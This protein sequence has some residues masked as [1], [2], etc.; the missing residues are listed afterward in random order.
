MGPTRVSKWN[1]LAECLLVLVVALPTFGL[2]PQATTFVAGATGATWIGSAGRVLSVALLGFYMPLLYVVGRGFAP[3]SI[4][5]KKISIPD[6]TICGQKFNVIDLYTNVLITGKI[7]SGKTSVAIWHLMGE[8][9]TVFNKSEAEIAADPRLAPLARIGGL[10]MDIKGEFCEGVLWFAHQA[11]RNILD[12]IVIIRPKVR[13]PVARFTDERGFSFFLSAL[14]VSTGTEFGKFIAQFTRP[15]GEK[16]PMDLNLRPQGERE[17]LETELRALELPV[18]GG[19]SPLFYIGWRWEGGKLVRVSHTP[20]FGKLTY[21]NGPDGRPITIEPPKTLR[22][23][24]M[25]GV[26][27]GLRFNLVNP[28]LS[29]A[30]VA[31]RLINIGK[32][33]DG[34]KNSGDNAYWDK[35]A[36]R[37][38]AMCIE[39]WRIVKPKQEISGP[40]IMR[41]VSHNDALKEIVEGLRDRAQKLE[42]EAGETK[43]PIRAKELKDLKRKADDIRKYFVD[44]WDKLEPKTKSIVDS[45]IQNMFSEFI[46]DGALQESFCSPT[47]F[48]FDDA[49]NKGTFFCFVAGRE[50]ESLAKTMQTALKMQFQ[51][52]ALERPTAP[53]MNQT[54]TVGLVIDECQASAVAGGASGQGDEHFMSLARQS[55]V[56]NVNATQSDSSLIAVIGKENANVYLQSY[57]GR[58]WFQNGDPETNKR[59]A[60]SCG[61]IY[62]ERV[63]LQTKDYEADIML[64]YHDS[65]F[66]KHPRMIKKEKDFKKVDRFA[67]DDFTSLD[68]WESVTINMGR[69]GKKDKVHRQKNFPSAYSSSENRPNVESLLR[70]YIQAYPEQLAF[71]VKANSGIS[72]FDHIP[73]ST[74]T[75]STTTAVATPT[76]QPATAP[77]A[78]N[79]GSPTPAASSSSVPPTQPSTPAPTVP[80]GPSAQPGGAANGIPDIAPQTTPQVPAPQPTPATP[81]TAP[82]AYSGNAANVPKLIPTTKITIRPAA[83]IPGSSKATSPTPEFSPE[84]QAAFDAGKLTLNDLETIRA[85]Y[86]DPKTNVARVTEAMEQIVH[87]PLLNPQTTVRELVQSREKDE[88]GAADRA[89]QRDGGVFGNSKMAAEANPKL[90]V[91]DSLQ[92]AESLDMAAEMNLR[93]KTHISPAHAKLQEMA[94]E[95]Q[96]IPTSLPPPEAVHQAIKAKLPKVRG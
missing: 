16:F 65:E 83:D 61:Q 77:S 69:K 85:Y 17:E 2:L 59:A 96:P 80:K 58:V 45:V 48:K 3:G 22:F 79:A 29:A 43:N 68:V 28:K 74:A 52:V 37:T 35:S 15:N 82:A 90:T 70:W 11:K 33:I 1:L 8:L 49:F 25:N 36:A 81:S 18:P 60:E 21:V 34:G 50:Y 4:S 54:R 66:E 31:K 64:G 44:S 38:V 6:F 27:N 71:R 39:G 10:C 55:K 46:T 24:E 40:D 86:R 94:N 19:P 56:I 41:I 75:G 9:F 47:T 63:D 20:E 76:T 73:G 13:I 14:S 67:S 7:G 72:M 89:A 57:G 23:V 78:P 91:R 5:S 62:K 51:S 93:Q 30:E 53:H 26:D 92:T 42:K 88:Q 12:E 32:L 84:T 95:T 87:Q